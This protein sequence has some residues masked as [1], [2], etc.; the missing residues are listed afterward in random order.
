MKSSK[1][2]SLLIG[3]FSMS[4]LLDGQT[5]TLDE[6]LDLIQ[7]NHPFFAKEALSTEIESNGR[8]VYLGSEDWLITS[9]PYFAR[10]NPLPPGAFSPER[11]DQTSVGAAVQR[12]FWKTGG[13][14]SFS[15]SSELT[16]QKLDDIVM[17]FDPP[18]VIS[19]GPSKYYQNNAYITYSQPLLQNYRGELDR[20]GYEISQ[21]SV[22]MAEVQAIENQEN[23]LLSM[24][25]QF[26]DWVLLSEQKIIATERL[27]LAERQLEQAQKKREANLVDEVDILRSV[28]AVRIAEQGRVLIDAHWKGKQAE[29]A[30]L[31]RTRELYTLSP[32]FSLYDPVDLPG[33]DEATTRLRKQSRLLRVV[34]I[35]QVQ[36]ERQQRGFDEMTKPQLYLNTQL[37]L[38]SGN[39]KFGD[40]TGFDKSDIGISLQFSYPLGNRSATMQVEKTALQIRQI[41][42]A[43]EEVALSL[44]SAL[45]NLLI[46]IEE[47]EKV[48]DLNRKQMET[49]KLKTEEEL[50]RYNQGRSDLTFVIQ[51]QD[52]EE[53]AKMFYAQNAATYHGLDLRLKALLDEL[54]ELYN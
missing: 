37:A 16:N 44:E 2:I 40:A 24:G 42:L 30:V 34:A 3:L 31:S 28:D 54:D 23:F 51:S 11:V 41:K 14:L 10:Q 12:V 43:E 52:N 4:S 6:F 39:E 53:S 50:E 46:Q 15:W 8:D 17:P 9:S 21:Y 19:A 45:Q 36:L 29:L 38:K 5:I 32:E 13:R 48:L 7:L 25:L 47:I 49:A 35:Q 20:L 26:L 33:L 27:H 1:S 22:D 18:V